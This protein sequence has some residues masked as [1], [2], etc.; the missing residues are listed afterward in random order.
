M[1]LDFDESVLSVGDQLL[2]GTWFSFLD[3][4]FAFISFLYK[5]VSVRPSSHVIAS[6]LMTLCFI[7]RKELGMLERI[8]FFVLFDSSGR[9]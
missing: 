4:C 6:A 8:S 1:I 3:L 5:F 9:G 7:I 2:C